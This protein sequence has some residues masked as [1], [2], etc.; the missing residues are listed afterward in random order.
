MKFELLSKEGIALMVV[1]FAAIILSH[2]FAPT[3]I[4]VVTS[5][6][7]TLMGALLLERKPKA[8]PEDPNVDASK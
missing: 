2:M 5:M 7:S 4:G 3:A 8:L 1:L 6:T